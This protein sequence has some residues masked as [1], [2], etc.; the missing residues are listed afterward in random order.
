MK[1][2]VQIRSAISATL[3]AVWKLTGFIRGVERQIAERAPD[4]SCMRALCGQVDVALGTLVGCLRNVARDGEQNT[5]KFSEVRKLS[6]P[7]I[8]SVY[9]LGYV[10]RKI[11]SESPSYRSNVLTPALCMIFCVIVSSPPAKFQPVLLHNGYPGSHI[12]FKKSLKLTTLS[13]QISS[14][15][16]AKIIKKL[17]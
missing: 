14:I 8:F 5:R 2:T 13:S 7:C 1:C 10:D 17:L 16:H 15:V 6:S 12:S 9:A 4:D 3:A 11:D